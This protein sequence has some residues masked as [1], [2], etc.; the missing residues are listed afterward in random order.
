MTQNL[1]QVRRATHECICLLPGALIGHRRT[2]E[3]FLTPR[4][5]KTAEYIEGRS[6]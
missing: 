3:L 5:P 4:N 1:A 2:E 6:G